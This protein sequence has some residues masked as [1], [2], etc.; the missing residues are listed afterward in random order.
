M[1]DIFVM[2]FPIRLAL[3]A[4]QDR[5]D[6]AA[7]GGRRI[8]SRPSHYRGR[9]PGFIPP[10][11]FAR[12]PLSQFTQT[13]GSPK[14]HGNLLFDIGENLPQSRK[15]P[16]LNIGRIYELLIPSNRPL[17]PSGFEPIELKVP[18]RASRL[19]PWSSNL[20]WKPRSISAGSMALYKASRLCLI[21][22]G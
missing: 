10:L 4:K 7:P 18:A 19:L 16:F 20:P 21:L 1:A 9:Q 12:I 14:S 3:D 17:L 2:R 22:N 5:V 8:D 13:F 15:M 6:A 11:V